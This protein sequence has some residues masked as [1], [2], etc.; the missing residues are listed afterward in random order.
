MQEDNFSYENPLF[1]ELLDGNALGTRFLILHNDETHTFDYV[2]DSLIEVCDHDSVQAE[3]CAF[4]VHYKGCCD[5]K[6]GEL[7]TLQNMQAE[8]VKRGLDATIN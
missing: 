6:K 5:V 3:Q 2:I 7:K 1:H 8:L 4:I